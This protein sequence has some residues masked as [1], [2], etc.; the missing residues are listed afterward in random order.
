MTDLCRHLFVYGTL[1]RGSG[2]K[3][4]RFLAQRACLVGPG[5]ISA[6]LYHLGRY[7]GMVPTAA[8]SEQVY[9]QVY[10]LLD[11]H[12]TLP[13]LDDYE[14]CIGKDTAPPL[15]ERRS[16]EVVLASGE[17]RTAWAYFYL[18]SVDEA[19]RIASGDYLAS[20]R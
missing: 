10:E 9:G 2:H 20:L 16:V 11:P 13:R 19:Q 12:D 7:P 18:G 1:R 5:S 3:M 15:F 8:P 14:G 17:T 4:A 6:R